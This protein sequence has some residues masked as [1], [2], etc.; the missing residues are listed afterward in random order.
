MTAMRPL[1]EELN[2]IDSLFALSLLPKQRHIL[3]NR[4]IT[5]LIVLIAVTV[6]AMT[7]L[8]PYSG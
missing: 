6:R 8:G 1:N 4:Q 2:T 7:A 3:S 5:A